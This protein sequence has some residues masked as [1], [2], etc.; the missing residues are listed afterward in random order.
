MRATQARTQEAREKK[1]GGRRI[2]HSDAGVVRGAGHH[3]QT[4][5]RRDVGTWGEIA[6]LDEGMQQRK[7]QW[8]WHEASSHPLAAAKAAKHPAH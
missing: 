4:T 3:G 2:D 8:K 7:W 6:A 5:Q 1:K